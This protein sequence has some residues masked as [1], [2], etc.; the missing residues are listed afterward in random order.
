MMDFVLAPENSEWLAL[1]TCEVGAPPPP[2]FSTPT[3]WKKDS[4][5]EQKK[6]W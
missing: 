2:L 4:M 1:H 3:W 5:Q 6:D